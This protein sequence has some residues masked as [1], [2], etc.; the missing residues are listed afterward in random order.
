MKLCYETWAVGSGVHHCTLRKK[1]RPK[2]TNF[3]ESLLGGD[4][5]RL[6]VSLTIVVEGLRAL[7]GGGKFSWETKKETQRNEFL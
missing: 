3:S 2:E 5:L 1:K 7:C 6:P 4:Y